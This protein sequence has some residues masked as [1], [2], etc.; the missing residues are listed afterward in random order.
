M[1]S[2][3]SAPIPSPTPRGFRSDRILLAG[4]IACLLF[5][6]WSLIPSRSGMHSLT[7]TAGSR[8]GLRHAFAE[9]LMQRARATGLTIDMIETRG[10]R[11]AIAAIVAGRVDVALVQGG[12]AI[13]P[14]AKLRQVAA[15]QVEPLHLVAK[16]EFAAAVTANLEALREHTVNIGD[17][18][19][20]TYRLALEVLWFAGVLPLGET[21]DARIRLT[22]LGPDDLDRITTRT[23]APDAVFLVSA[24]PSPTIRRLVREFDYR[25]VPLPFSEAFSLDALREMAQ[26]AM[27]SSAAAAATTREMVSVERAN[28]YET[29]IPPFA[30]SVDPDVPATPT[31]TL[32]TRLLLIANARVSDEAVQRLLTI[33]FSTDMVRIAR[34]PLDPSLL[35]LPP[36]FELH[37][38]TRAY[39][40]RTKPIIAGDLLDYW[41]K[42][43]SI[44]AAVAGG[45]FFIWQ[46]LNRRYQ[47]ERDMSFAAY[48]R[49]V[50]E[51]EREA[52]KLERTSHIPLREL[53]LIQR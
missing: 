33:L 26:P 1:S 14:Q 5:L 32:G 20:G 4:A 35:A 19:S 37:A 40:Q 46:W 51:L 13:G 21:S 48:V 8:G 2:P 53:M 10:S 29:E 50:N 22:T 12:L 41:E 49:K 30:Y 6:A 27:I 15:L 45:L 23:D 38:G 3:A 18:G 11:D 43:V 17:P 34:P 28:V 47:R 36:E 44:G 24:M 7:I 39:L 9:L 31:R 16:A 52:R 42:S 25:L